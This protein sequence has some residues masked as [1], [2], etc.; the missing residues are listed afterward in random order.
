MSGRLAVPALRAALVLLALG[1]PLAAQPDAAPL[2]LEA[3]G[4][5]LGLY[6]ADVA[7]AAIRHDG[8]G[9]PMVVVRLGPDAA[10]RLA[11][12]TRGRTGETLTL[13]FCGE[14]LMRPEL[15]SELDGGTFTIVGRGAS[16]G[17]LIVAIL[18]GREG[19]DAQAF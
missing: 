8:P 4:E 11:A 14:E 12:L 3:A 18:E 9:F 15:R 1:R 10:L 7:E 5:V 17:Q 16:H 2:V 13:R 19:C 6:P